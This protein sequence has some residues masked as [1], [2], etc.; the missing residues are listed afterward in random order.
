MFDL[1]DFGKCSGGIAGA[2]ETAPPR[3]GKYPERA[4]DLERG[5]T[6]AAPQGNNFRWN[7]IPDVVRSAWLIPKASYGVPIKAFLPDVEERPGHSEETT[8]L[9]D[10]A[11]QL[12]PKSRQGCRRYK[13]AQSQHVGDR[14][15]HT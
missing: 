4:F 15:P 5:L 11:A 6:P 12:A 14:M 13:G 1:I 3:G 7:V 10:F 8:G 2:S 9:T